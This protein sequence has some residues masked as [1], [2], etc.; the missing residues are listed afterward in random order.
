MHDQEHSGFDRSD[1][2][3][4]DGFALRVAVVH[5]LTFV[6]LGAASAGILSLKPTFLKIGKVLPP[7]TQYAFLAAVSFRSYWYLIALIWIAGIVGVVQ[8]EKRAGRNTARGV[9]WAWVVGV[10]TLLLLLAVAVLWPLME[11]N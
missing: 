11:R 6:A 9:S 5:A 1:T 4:N 2:A 3:N 8:V 10:V 7:T